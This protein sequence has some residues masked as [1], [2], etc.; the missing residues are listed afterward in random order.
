MPSAPLPSNEAERLD[1]LH[2][3]EVLDTPAE[4]TFDALA[5][6]L[7]HLLG[8]PIAAVSLVDRDREWLKAGVGT[9]TTQR[10]RCHAFC[11]HTI[12][13]SEPLIVPDATKDTRFADNP[14]VT[15]SGIRFYAGAPIRTRDGY[16]LGALCV[17]DRCPRRPNDEQVRLLE[18]LAT[19]A[20][21]LI[22]ARRD[23]ALAE[24]ATRAKTR[25]LANMTHEI[26]TPLTAILGFAD[27]LHDGSFSEPERDDAIQTIQRN[28]Q[29]LLALINDVLDL[30]RIEAGNLTVERVPVYPMR[31]VAEL[32][33]TLRAR[34]SANSVDLRL[35]FHGPIPFI[36]ETDPL[37]LR[38]I[39]SS[40]IG[41]AIKFSPRGHVDIIVRLADP[42]AEELDLLLEVADDGVGMSPEQIQRVFEPFAQGDDATATRFGGCGL[43]LALGRELAQALGAT[44][45]V[46]SRQ[47]QGSTFTITLPLGPA[48]S[49]ELVEP[50]TDQP[51]VVDEPGNRFP[52][53]L[54][55][56]RV[57]LAEHCQDD[58]KLI[59]VVLSKAGAEVE[60]EPNGRDAVEQAMQQA[61]A[62]CPFDVIMLDMDMPDEG[63]PAAVRTLRERGYTGPILGMTAHAT[64][65]L[66]CR[67]LQAGCTE[68]LSKPINRAALIS[69]VGRAAGIRVAA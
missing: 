42:Q 24:Q 50:E 29:H 25:F 56:V 31:L 62:G 4:E 21:R 52:P 51:A 47:G 33:S 11:A 22:E 37:R 68:L 12:L 17:K 23:A 60:I 65:V 55:G 54:D 5:A 53:R 2:R 1:A 26:R 61:D 59:V 36:I 8:T 40:L 3:L 45:S 49:L 46:A 30:S 27:L 39:L 67:C 34:A 64:T 15:K 32:H 7:A 48:R 19:V 10:D 43:G 16:N 28:G 35:A 41:N 14:Q 57:L 6:S 69:T 44:I 66:S 9:A 58:Q 63:G 18:Q 13:R 20:A 38:Q